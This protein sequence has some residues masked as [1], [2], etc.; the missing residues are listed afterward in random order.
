MKH[1]RIYLLAGAL[2]TLALGGCVTTGS[3]GST[4]SSG[5]GVTVYG[6]I[7]AGVQR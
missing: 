1:V 7:D 6:T 4:S 2:A 3:S 5:S